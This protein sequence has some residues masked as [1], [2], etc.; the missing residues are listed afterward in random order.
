[1]VEFRRQNLMA[2]FHF[3]CRFDVIFCRNVMIYFK[4]ETRESLI[5]R[6]VDCLREG[7]YLMVGH[8]ESL[9]GIEHRLKYIQPSVY[10]KA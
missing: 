4:K 3:N 8:A 5:Q 1:M 9:T 6:A 7:G 2:P 10:R